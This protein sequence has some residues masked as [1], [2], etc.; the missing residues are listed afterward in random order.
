LEI[1][2]LILRLAFLSFSSPTHSSLLCEKD[3]KKKWKI[4]EV[5][6]DNQWINY[7]FMHTKCEN[8]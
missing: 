8:E 5:V 6:L 4:N 3:G 7:L 2:P 1:I